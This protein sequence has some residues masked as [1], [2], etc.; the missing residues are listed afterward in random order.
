MAGM[1]VSINI[2]DGSV[3]RYEK[4]TQY[5]KQLFISIHI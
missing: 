1:I 5:E 4:I 2:H 3:G